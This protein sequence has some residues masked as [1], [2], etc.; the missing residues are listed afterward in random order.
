M[1]DLKACPFCGTMPVINDR[2]RVRPMCQC[3]VSDI[4]GIRIEAWNNRPIEDQLRAE[5]ARLEELARWIPI[6]ERLPELG[7]RV[8]VWMSND[9][10]VIATRYDNCWKNDGGQETHNITHWMY[11]SEE[12][13]Y[14][15]I[16]GE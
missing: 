10:Q 1:D 9:Y 8:Q 16:K 12:P 11:L 15:K 14:W 3:P 13:S 4:S 6:E 7:K 2:N 5:I